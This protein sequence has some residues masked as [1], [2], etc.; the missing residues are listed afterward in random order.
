MFPGAQLF[1]GNSERLIKDFRMEWKL[2]V[3]VVYL[4]FEDFGIEWGHPVGLPKA[5]G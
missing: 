2:G 5:H 4:N 1:R 3:R